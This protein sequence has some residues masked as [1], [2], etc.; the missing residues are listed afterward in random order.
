MGL[1]STAK[2][3]QTVVDMAD[4]LYTKLSQLKAQLQE[5]QDTVEATNER[6]DAIDRELAEQRALVEAIADEQGVDTDA[7]LEDLSGAD[8]EGKDTG[9]DEPDATEADVR[10]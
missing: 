8:A 7:V 3:L 5:T 1:G 9:T 4:K 10:D 2:K 6:V